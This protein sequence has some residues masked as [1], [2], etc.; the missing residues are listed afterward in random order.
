[1]LMLIMC[2]TH[3]HTHFAAKMKWNAFIL[4]RGN[5]ANRQVWFQHSGH[6]SLRCQR[7]GELFPQLLYQIMLTDH[8]AVLT[9]TSRSRDGWPCDQ[10][11]AAS[12]QKLAE[13]PLSLKTCLFSSKVFRRFELPLYW[14]LIWQVQGFFCFFL[15]KVKLKTEKLKRKKLTFE[16]D[17]IACSIREVW[18]GEGNGCLTRKH[19]HW[20]DM[21]GKPRLSDYKCGNNLLFCPLFV[22]SFFSYVCADN[23]DCV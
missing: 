18:R 16:C 6:D 22:F 10:P 9:V 5:A 8:P 2:D 23:S 13:R 12:V 15:N 20:R 1:M 7:A 19:L 14:R 3:T 21:S 4:G 11:T 17:L